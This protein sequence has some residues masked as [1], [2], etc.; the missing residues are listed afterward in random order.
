M[1]QGAVNGASV[2]R[3]DVTPLDGSG[4]TFSLAVS[5]AKWT[6]TA[7]A[8]DF[9]PAASIVVTHRTAQRGRSFRGRTYIPF[10]GESSL[11]NGAISSITATQTA[12]TAFVA[13]M[14]AAA[15]PLVVAT[16][17]HGSFSVVTSCTVQS[18]AGTQRRRQSRLRS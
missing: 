6:G 2:T 4:A 18:I 14:S 5:G 10:I 12:W 7:G 3:L 15:N 13:A 11:V 8:G 16:Y 1:W 9:V 17:L